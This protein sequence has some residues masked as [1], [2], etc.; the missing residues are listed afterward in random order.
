[1]AIWRTLKWRP[2]DVF[3]RT[4][5]VPNRYGWTSKVFAVVIHPSSNNIGFNNEAYIKEG[6]SR[7]DDWPIAAAIIIMVEI[8]PKYT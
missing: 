4:L 8:F 3:A 7:Y 6:V 5:C 1:M 2:A